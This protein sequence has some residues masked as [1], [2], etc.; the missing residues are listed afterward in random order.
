MNNYSD[1]GLISYFSSY[2]FASGSSTRELARLLNFV[3]GGG[4]DPTMPIIRR[5]YWKIGYFFSLIKNREVGSFA[6]QM[7]WCDLED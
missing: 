1:R 4:I 2:F 5:I 7:V 6:F 3:N